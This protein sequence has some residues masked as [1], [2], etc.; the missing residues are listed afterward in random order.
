MESV[1][2]SS[3]NKRS[4][5]DSY[6]SERITGWQ[7][8]RNL[9]FLHW[10]VSPELLRKRVPQQ[11]ELDLWRG[12]AFVG[13]VAFVM[14]RVQPQWWPRRLAFRFLE[15]NV[16]TYVRFGQQ[17]GIYFFSLDANHLLAVFAARAGWGLPYYWSCMRRRHNS[18]TYDYCLQRYASHAILQV[19]YRPGEPR[20]LTD[21]QSLEDFL[22]E[23][24]ILF[25]ERA[26][27]IYSLQVHHT[28]Y[29]LQD[30]E[31]LS[32]RQTLLDIAGLKT[33][34]PVEPLLAH[35][36]PGV[37]VGIGRLTCEHNP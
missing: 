14:D 17:R 13:I 32:F 37:D 18:G 4:A 34:N 10:T 11:L 35:Y 12:E 22:I 6:T 3:M 29:S 26:G 33:T 2:L 27:K 30:V 28:P 21:R 31:I 1:G 5:C 15:T 25:V 23:R 7:T 16:R 19:R 36:S 8:W 9:V 20:A 24:Y